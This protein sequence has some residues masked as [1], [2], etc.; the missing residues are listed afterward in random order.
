MKPKIREMKEMR[1]ENKKKK[2]KIG[3]LLT[4]GAGLF[5]AGAIGFYSRIFVTGANLRYWC[6]LRHKKKDGIKG[7]INQ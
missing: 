5:V 7:E 2:P 3:E 6:W 4:W 1:E